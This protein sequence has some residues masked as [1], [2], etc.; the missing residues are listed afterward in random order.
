MA[1]I[2]RKMMTHNN[3]TMSVIEWA[4]IYTVPADLIRARLR[5]GW[6]TA[7]ALECEP[8]PKPPSHI[9]GKKRHTR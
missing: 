4:Q 1:G 8:R 3:V 6:S 2:P 5:L 7:Q 9:R